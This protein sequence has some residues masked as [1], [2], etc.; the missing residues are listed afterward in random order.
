M[1]VSALT[2]R[3]V[4]VLIVVGLSAGCGNGD[5]V[6]SLPNGYALYRSAP[7]IFF[8][9]NEKTV[10]VDAI[11][12]EYAVVGNIVTGYVEHRYQRPASERRGLSGG[13][14]VINTLNKKCSK[15]LDKKA[16]VDE[17]ASEGISPPPELKQPIPADAG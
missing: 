1:E 16:W 8:I 7:D 4:A 9:G 12:K 11:V 17:L 13:Y 6:I 3:T 2:R 15:E 14:F 5:Y 10:V